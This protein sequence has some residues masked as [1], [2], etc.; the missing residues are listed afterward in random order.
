M[1][2][3]YAFMVTNFTDHDYY[4]ATRSITFKQQIT[5][6]S[7]N[8]YTIQDRTLEQK[9]ELFSVAVKYHLQPKN[10]D[11]CDTTARVSIVDDDGMFLIF[12][13][14]QILYFILLMNR[15]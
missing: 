6:I 5:D 9:E 2:I 10:I 4:P 8:I 15:Y 3:M 11:G 12:I 7:F 1:I 13:I 14:A